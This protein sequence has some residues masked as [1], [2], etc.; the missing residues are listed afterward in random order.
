MRLFCLVCTSCL[1]SSPPAA[2]EAGTSVSKCAQ[3]PL[4]LI[5]N[6]MRKYVVWRGEGSD[7]GNFWAELSPHSQSPTSPLI[8]NQLLL[9]VQETTSD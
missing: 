1:H 2:P 4:D 6:S 9:A 8:P 3:L 7:L 5:P